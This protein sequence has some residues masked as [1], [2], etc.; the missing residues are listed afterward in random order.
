M[1][2][3][4][5]HFVLLPLAG[6]EKTR[7]GDVIDT[8]SRTRG[9]VFFIVI[10]DDIP[11]S[12]YKRLLRTGRAEWVLTS[13]APQEIF[14]IISRHTSGTHAP[15]RRTDPVVVSFVPSAGG[16]GNTTLAIEAA[17]QLTKN[18]SSVYERICIIDLD[19]QSS[20]VCDHLDIGPHLQIEE[21]SSNPERL[22]EQLF[23]IFISKHQSGLDVFA[24]PRSLFSV[25]DLNIAALDKL[26]DMISARYDLI[27]VDLPLT[28]F[29]W[30][31]HVIAISDSAI[32]AGTNTIPG[33]R[34]MAETMAAVRNVCRTSCQVAAIINRCERRILG[35]VAGRQ[36]VEKVL[37]REKIFYVPNDPVVIQSVNI[38]TPLV[39]NHA[40]GKIAKEIAALAAYC[41]ALK[42]HRP[43]SK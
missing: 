4:E 41:A 12:D 17:A 7:I 22:D 5:E 31:A 30:T 24:A 39:L 15:A 3:T 42:P 6:T 34:R 18:K 1:G 32:V 33:L 37:G 35:G 9:P 21:I 11:A 8:A 38:G 36:Q 27:V 26:F 14:D 16:V 2:V 20:H 43:L 13:T 40:T 10:S 25:C 28:W 23:N 19:F 29:A